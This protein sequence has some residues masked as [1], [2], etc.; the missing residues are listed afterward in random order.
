MPENS[1]LVVNAGSHSLE[2]THV[3][4][5]QEI[6]DHTSIDADPGSDEARTVLDDFLEAVG[7]PAAVGHRMVHGGPDLRQTAVVDDQVRRH[8]PLWIPRTVLCLDRAPSSR[9]PR[10]IG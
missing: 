3:G 2:L 1:V 8:P 7:E 10:T 5:R 9:G 6:L 4:E